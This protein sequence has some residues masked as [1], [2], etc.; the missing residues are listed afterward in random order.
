MPIRRGWFTNTDIKR[1]EKIRDPFYARLQPCFH[2]DMDYTMSYSVL[3][4]KM[5]GR[6]Q[7]HALFT[8]YYAPTGYHPEKLTVEG[9]TRTF[10]GLR[11]Q[12]WEE[13][14][15]YERPFVEKS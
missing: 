14:T 11:A 15:V 8:T 3:N 4:L 1:L 2:Y 6:W 7:Q 9:L 5:M 12:R 10:F 13:L